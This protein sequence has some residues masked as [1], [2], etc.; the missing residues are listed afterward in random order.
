MCVTGADKKKVFFFFT[1]ILLLLQPLPTSSPSTD[2]Y[3]SPTLA[4]L[5]LALVTDALLDCVL[6]RTSPFRR[7]ASP[8]LLLPA[9]FNRV[10]FFPFKAGPT[11]TVCSSSVLRALLRTSCAFSTRLRCFSSA[12]WARAWAAAAAAA[13]ALLLPPAALLAEAA[14]PPAAEGRTPGP[15]PPPPPQPPLPQLPDELEELLTPADLTGGEC[16]TVPATPLFWS[17]PPVVLGEALGGGGEDDV[18]LLPPLLAL[19]L[20]LLTGAPGVASAAAAT[21]AAFAEARRAAAV[22]ALP[23]VEGALRGAAAGRCFT[24]GFDEL[25]EPVLEMLAV[26]EALSASEHVRSVRDTVLSLCFIWFGRGLE[27]RAETPGAADFLA[28]VGLVASF[29]GRLG[30]GVR[31]AAEVPLEARRDID[32]G[33]GAAATSLFFELFLGESSKLSSGE[34]GAS[35]EVGAAE[36]FETAGARAVLRPK[37]IFSGRFRRA[38]YTQ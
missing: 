32:A 30:G 10:V 27:R 9:P 13:F 37:N 11:P 12:R 31:E 34:A 5:D 24:A 22:G 15:A 1:F 38:S 25:A 2:A 16:C 28:E 18:D 35:A 3:A 19:L 23:V 21:A 33:F 14:P 7:P 4:P 6:L 29:G 20:L 8:P 26:S 17:N 36:V